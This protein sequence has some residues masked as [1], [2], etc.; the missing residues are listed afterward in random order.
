MADGGPRE[1]VRRDPDALVIRELT[2]DRAINLLTARGRWIKPLARGKARPID[3][4]REH[5]KGL[6]ADAEWPTVPL[7]SGIIGAPT[8]RPDGSLLSTIGYDA[9]T[10]ALFASSTTFGEIKTEPTRLDALVALE[11]LAAPFEEFPFMGEASRAAHLATILA[12]CSR[13]GYP[14][15]PA[16]V[17]T[18]NAPGSGK[19]LLADAVGIIAHGIAPA[20][21]PFASARDEFRKLLAAVLLAG[22]PVM[23]VDN[24]DRPVQS[25]ELCNLLTTDR[26]GDRVLGESRRVKL[27]ARVSILIT[28]NNVHLVGDLT[29]RALVVAI[30]PETERPED[31][32]DFAISDLRGHLRE[33]RGALA[34][35]AITILRAFRVAD[36]PRQAPPLGSFEDWSRS[37][38][39]PLIWLGMP[40][41]VE[42]TTKAR[43]ADPE[44]ERLSALLEAW[45]AR[46]EGTPKTAAEAVET[47]KDH[48]AGSYTAPTLRAALIDALGSEREL[49]AG[50]LGYY[51][52]AR[53][54]RIIANRRFE[55]VGKGWRASTLEGT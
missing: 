52:R 43:D 54:R 46:F 33:A 31:R 44:R 8:L 3:F 25:A 42:T 35:A 29:R 38:R 48:V 26:Y 2:V 32:T 51:L 53:E 11:A 39:E 10:G 24:V 34:A 30:D 19:T 16:T 27:D 49:E 40:D 41:P 22:D 50:R 28:G 21:V 12:A 5:A 47:A 45:Q 55:R 17:Y 14:T 1:I 9:A 13:R 36:P 6:L 20:H 23:L 37:V 4:P 15:A 7:L 18:A